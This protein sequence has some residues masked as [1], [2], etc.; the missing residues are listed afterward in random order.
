MKHFPFRGL[1][2]AAILVAGVCSSVGL[3]PVRA[4]DTEHLQYRRSISVGPRATEE[5]VA[6]RLD[7]AV[8]AVTA[9][10]FADVRVVDTSGREVSR[11]LRRASVVKTR[12]VRKSFPVGAPRVKP[13]PGGGLEIEFTIDSERYPAAVDGFR[14]DTPL[15]NFEQ[16]VQVHRLDVTGTWQPVGDDTLLF[17]YSQWMD[18]RQIDVAFPHGQRQPPGGTWRI[19]V[20]ETTIEQ[21]SALSE[22]IRTLEGGVETGRKE[23]IAVVRQ[24]FRIDSIHA[25]H[26]DDI[27]EIQLAD[28]ID[29]PLADFRVDEEVKEKR[30]R[31]RVTSH[32]EPITDRNFKRLARIEGIVPDGSGQERDRSLSR[33]VLGS[34]RVQRFDLRGISDEQLLI[35]IPESRHTDYEIVIDNADSPPLDVTAVTAVGPAYELVFLARPGIDYRLAYGGVTADDRPFPVPQYDTAALDVALAAGKVPLEGGFEAVEEIAVVPVERP[36]LARLLGNRFLIGGMIVLLALVL[37]LSLFRAAKRI[38]GVDS[39]AGR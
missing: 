16:R 36:W 29:V 25:W 39:D 7:A 4:A 11:I 24:P 18:T 23:E 34:S 12:S 37:G 5:L 13:L 6:V 31:I 33:S 17:D 1:L 19:T 2:C 26:T 27:A 35:P 21:Q 15:K 28:G 8:A 10:G 3:Q 22:L 30:T 14:I 38:D 9:D 20:D 32:R